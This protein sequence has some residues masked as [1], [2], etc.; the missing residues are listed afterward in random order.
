[1]KDQNSTKLMVLIN[2]VPQIEFDRAFELTESQNNS[3]QLIDKKL[4]QGFE[5]HGIKLENPT[6]EDK[7]QFVSANLISSLLADD[8]EVAAASCAYIAKLLPDLKQIK[9]IE[10][11]GEISIE[12]VFDKDHR[13]ESKLNFVPA[14]QLKN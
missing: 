1:M 8:D 10:K 13:Q 12:L 4:N 3:L 2:N 6:H 11:N 7:I 14:D 9:S 5:L